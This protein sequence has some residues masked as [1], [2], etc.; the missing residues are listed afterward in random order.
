MSGTWSGTISSTDGPGT[1]T[2]SLA[3]NGTSVSGTVSINQNARSGPGTIVGTLSGA[4]VGAQ[5]T[6]TVTYTSPGGLLLER[7]P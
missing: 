3:Q 6:F 2:W 4:T 5:L 1:M 7:T